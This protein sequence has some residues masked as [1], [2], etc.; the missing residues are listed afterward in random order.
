M[1]KLGGPKCKISV[2]NFKDTAMDKIY[3]EVLLLHGYTKAVIRLSQSMQNIM[4]QSKSKQSRVIWVDLTTLLLRCSQAIAMND[5]QSA[6]E[7]IKQIKQHSSPDGDGVQR[8]AHIFAIGLEARLAGTGNELSLYVQPHSTREHVTNILKAYNL[9]IISNPFVRASYFFA[10]HT[11]LNAIEKAS[12]VHI[13][14]LGIGFCSFQWPHLM[15]ALS[16]KEVKIMKLRITGIDNRQPSLRPIERVEEQGR[17][18]QEYARNFGIPFEYSGIVAK[19]E[20]I[21]IEDLNIEKDEMVIVNSMYRFKNIGAET[22]TNSP[23][24]KV[25]DVIRRIKPH[26]FIQGTINESFSGLLFAT[27]FKQILL[28]YSAMFDLLDSTVPPDDKVRHFIESKLWA[29]DVFNLIACE[30]SKLVENPETYKQWGLRNLRAGFE[31]M[32]I[33]RAIVKKI[34]KKVTNIYDKKFFIE[35]DKK[36]LLFGWKGR[37]MYTLSTWQVKEI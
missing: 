19:W 21:C 32:P 26:I 6:N 33:D 2:L 36:W 4:K 31:Q 5:P 18:L 28:H 9:F 1:S 7:L 23:R 34:K 16:K 37:T 8:M 30:E 17:R 12:K 10:N 24:N 25:L 22:D 27:R 20:E 13:I 14:H 11:I 29:S 15:L 3:A 35:E